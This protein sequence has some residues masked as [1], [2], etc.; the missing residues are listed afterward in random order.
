MKDGSNLQLPDYVL[1]DFS[2]EATGSL[3]MEIAFPDPAFRAYIAENYDDNSDGLL[4]PSEMEK[5][6]EARGLY[7]ENKNIH[8]LEGIQHFISLEILVAF[9]NEISSIDV[10][11]NLSLNSINVSN[12]K[13]TSINLSEN[14]NLTELFVHNNKLGSLNLSNH[15]NLTYLTVS[16]NEFSS[17]D[18]SNNINLK[19][20]WAEELELASLDISHNPNLNMLRLTNNKLT[21]LDI[22]KHPNLTT[23][24]IDGNEFTSLDLSSCTKLEELNINA[25]DFTSLD[26][27]SNTNLQ[28]LYAGENRFSELDLSA[29]LHLSTLDL[30][31]NKFTSLDLSKHTALKVISLARNPIKSESLKLPEE[32]VIQSLNLNECDI[33]TID[34]S[35]PSLE[36]LYLDYNSRLRSVD[37]TKAPNLT[38]VQCQ[39]TLVD[40]VD[41]SHCADYLMNTFVRGVKYLIL[42]EDQEAA[43]I[44]AAKKNEVIRLAEGEV[45]P[46]SVFQQQKDGVLVK[47]YIA[48]YG[49]EVGERGV[50]WSSSPGPTVD[51]STVDGGSESGSYSL[52]VTGMSI[53][54]RYYIRPYIKVDGSVV[55]GDETILDRSD[56]SHD[57]V[58]TQLQK[59]TQ[60]NGINVIFM[61]DGFTH[62]D[63]EEGN[64]LREMNVAMDAFFMLEPAQSLRSYFN[65]Y[66]VNTVSMSNDYAAGETALEVLFGGEDAYT[67]GNHGKVMEYAQRTGVDLSKAVI[68][69][70]A[71]PNGNQWGGTCH[72]LS[73]G[74]AITYTCSFIEEDFK[75]TICHEV[76]GHGFARLADEYIR[77]LEGISEWDIRSHRR[78]QK[79][80]W[81]ANIDFTNNL[82][83]ILWK[84]FIGDPKYSYVG[85][86]EGGFT[87]LKG[88]WRPEEESCMRFN[89]PYFNAPSRNAIY[90]RVMELAGQ[91]YSFEDFKRQ[92]NV[93][94]P[95][96]MR[97]A[98]DSNYTKQHH[99]PV[100]TGS[101]R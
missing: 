37:F 10:F 97:S 23:L 27:S 83:E 101:P 31:T 19:T 14:V 4:S 38:T 85:A 53:G 80:G 33:E 3:N 67:E 35:M 94:P 93:T 7:V 73:S 62:Q 57:G 46:L 9:G 15:V 32:N 44:G 34:L 68:S 64:Y 74:L 16:N 39:Y 41:I 30:G 87:Y 69:V 36:H 91:T 5:I 52:T 66:A 8:S 45:K 26:L 11:K 28:T 58:V 2:Q 84:Q 96:N 92:D 61:G 24:W 55:Y 71:K 86:Y 70:T 99:P 40:F 65:V 82:E 100:F 72:F 12:N 95:E 43:Y 17:L 81:W 20:L 90:R 21:S 78:K 29:N 13:L 77:T 47:S 48:G 42:R 59:A 49:K 98:S 51:D 22:S 6:K 88:V 50:C 79:N 18:I 56:Y 1:S 89:T 25:N 63:I 54:Q 75:K 76:L 60:G